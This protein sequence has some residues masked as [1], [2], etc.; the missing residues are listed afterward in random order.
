MLELVRY[1]NEHYGQEYENIEYPTT[2]KEIYQTY[3]IVKSYGIKDDIL[4]DLLNECV[5]PKPETIK[6]KEMYSECLYEVSDN[7]SLLNDLIY[8]ETSFLKLTKDDFE[9]AEGDVIPLS[10]TEPEVTS[11]EVQ[12]KKTYFYELTP[13][14]DWI[15][16]ENDFEKLG[17][18]LK[19][20]NE[21]EEDIVY[22]YQRPVE[23]VTQD[24]MISAF[25]SNLAFINNGKPDYE[26][27][28]LVEKNCF[29]I[30]LTEIDDTVIDF[31][32][33]LFKIDT[34]PTLPS[35]DDLGYYLVMGRDGKL[36]KYLEDR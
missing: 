34:I 26:E 35:F 32:L 4:L 27:K 1:F 10:I 9:V 24:N 11:M 29:Y 17:Y 12:N 5:L 33:E 14:L 23:V 22:E 25:Y 16:D 31:E 3:Q 2:K 30:Q 28:N 36:Y 8:K 18:N 7:G 21:D 20:K 15:N 13:K 6:E 19:F